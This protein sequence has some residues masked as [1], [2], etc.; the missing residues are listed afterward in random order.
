MPERVP[1]GDRLE[2]AIEQRADVEERDRARRGARQRAAASLRRTL[3][4][5]GDHRRL[6]LPRRARASSRS[7][8]SW[9][10]IGEIAPAWLAGDGRAPG[11]RARVPVGAAAPRAARRALAP[12][13]RLAARGQRA[14]EGRAR[15]R[16]GGR[17]APVPD[18][19]QSRAANGRAP[20]PG[21]PRRTCSSFAVVLALPVL[22]LPAL[23]RGGVD[24]DLVEATFVGLAVFAVLVRARRAAARASTGRWRGSAAPSSGPQPPAPGPAAAARGLPERLL[25]ERDRILAT[26][27]PRWKRAL[28]ATVG[29]WAFD[30]ATLLAALAAVGLD[31]PPG[32]RAARLLHRAG[33]RP[34]PDHAGRPRLR[35]GGPDRDARARRRGGG[36]RRA[37]DVRLPPVLLL[38]AAAAGAGRRSRCTAAA[39]GRRTRGAHRRR[40][41]RWRMTWRRSSGATAR[42]SCAGCS[43]TT[44]SRGCARA[45]SRTWPSRASARSRAAGTRARAGSSRTSATGP[46]SPPTRRSS[47]ARGWARSPRG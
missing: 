8:S 28:A 37:G 18:A 7:L 40:V 2:Q 27:G 4:W 24:R 9:R 19:G 44:R 41:S 14:V 6:A 35:R 22:A 32:A 25:R 39:T 38:A 17:G 36:R 21:S 33:A 42:A 13:D 43:T 47:A 45:S 31:A 46:G 10:D 3:F 12:G 26:L 34:G 1:I 29:R 23:M 30:Y 5:L 20:W 15:R 16:R 11:G